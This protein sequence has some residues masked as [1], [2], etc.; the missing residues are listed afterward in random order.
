MFKEKPTGNLIASFRS[1]TSGVVRERV[2]MESCCVNYF[3]LN[4]YVE[5]KVDKELLNANNRIFNYLFQK[6]EGNVCERL[7]LFISK[8]ELQTIVMKLAYGKLL[9]ID[10]IVTKF[11]KEY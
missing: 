1:Y 8:D 11:Y 5:A 3:R 6:V 10:G 4:L 9:G 2:V 7:V